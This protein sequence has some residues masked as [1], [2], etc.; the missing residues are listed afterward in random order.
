LQKAAHFAA[1]ASKAAC[2]AVLCRRSR[3]IILGHTVEPQLS[4]LPRQFTN[5]EQMHYRPLGRTDMRVSVICLGTMNMGEQ[6]TEAEGHAQ[7]D[8]ALAHGV[9]FIDTAELYAIPP[10]RE[11]QGRSEEI[12]GS[13]L[14]AR[15]NRA[16]VVLASKVCGRS[17]GLKWMRDGGRL[18]DLSRAQIFAAIEGSLRRL[19][20]D[21][22]DLY[23]V[24]WP[25][26]PMRLFSGLAYE[27]VEADF[28]PIEETLGAL[29]ELVR[30]GKVRA[31]GLSNE[32]PWGTMRYL[33]AA[34]MAA[35]ARVA[36]IQNA[37]NLLNRTFETGLSEIAYREQVG[38]LAYSP[39]AQGY[40]TGKYE[41]GALPAGSRK[42]LFNRLQ[43]YETPQA[44]AA[45]TAYVQLARDHG[46]DPAQMALQFVTTR[47]F[48]TSN[49]IGA[50]TMDQLRT[51]IASVEVKL[52][53]ELL[54]A[55][56]AIHLR[57]PNPCP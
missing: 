46:L 42:A 39:L 10:R 56:D 52:S 33:A 1:R 6:N 45:I 20:T 28:I 44:G 12:V 34:E 3:K 8:Y 26:R 23:Q 30:Q 21:H 4:A 31:I 37:Y 51:N 38:L 19:R 14:A 18:P 22:I 5:E 48:V 24:H 40:L 17:T 25:D 57:S 27:H 41:D 55:I 49:I 43:R 50:T 29:D 15:G 13:W 54:R 9:N 36:S 35:S 7:L 2:R 32:T 47:P 16:D 11:T 53:D